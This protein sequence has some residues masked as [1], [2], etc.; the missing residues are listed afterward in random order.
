DE[1][2]DEQ[3]QMAL[4]MVLIKQANY[5]A[6]EK[7][8]RAVLRLRPEKMQAHYFLS[9]ALYHQ[10]ERMRQKKASPGRQL[11]LYREAADRARQATELKPDHAFAHIFLG[12][13]LK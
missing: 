9:T 11:D 8:L 13:S 1:F 2:P 6:A 5:E 3:A 4:A 10:A 7:V 12:L